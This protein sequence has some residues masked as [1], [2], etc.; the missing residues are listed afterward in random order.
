[1][2]TESH[3]E[4]DERTTDSSIFSFQ[5]MKFR[6]NYAAKYLNPGQVLDIGCGLGFGFEF[7]LPPKFE[8]MGVDYSQE[9]I[10]RARE[11][12]PQAKFEAMAVPPLKFPDNSLHN[13][14]CLELIEH[15]PT[16][17]APKLLDEC[18][19]VL[20]E[21]GILF[22]T[23]PNSKNRG[24]VMPDGHYY[25]YDTEEMMALLKKSGF[26]IVQK[27]G[28]FLSLYKDRYKQNWFSNWRSKLYKTSAVPEK[29]HLFKKADIS[30]ETISKISLLKKSILRFCLRKLAQTLN[31]LGFW[32]P[33]R[34]EYQ[35]WVL[36]KPVNM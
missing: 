34:A 14:L 32:F 16:F 13:I 25:E 31:L 35:V 15:L 26:A 24:S 5:R 7:L 29:N 10:I 30:L 12:C 28:L 6:Y 23:T 1:M 3:K 18:F 19:R 20:R 27:G 9:T 11:R 33:S 2:K 8:Y 21:G 22:L 17:E 4:I 36:S